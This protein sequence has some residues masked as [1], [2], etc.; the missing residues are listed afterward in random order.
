MTHS[1]LYA[2]GVVH[3]RLRPVRHRLRYAV[4]Y[5]LIDL[6]ELPDL[7]ARL[8]LFA[9]DRFGLF[10]FHQRDHGGQQTGQLRAW[11]ERHVR[12]AGLTDR[13]GDIRILCMP[14]ILGY[15]FNPISVYFCYAQGGG[16]VAMLYEVRNTFGER[17]SYLIPVRAQNETVRQACD[18]QFYVSPFMP[19]E[20]AYRFRVE[21][22]GDTIRLG[23][24]AADSEG[25]V[26]ATA[27]SGR[28]EVL[29]DSVLLRH[30]LR[31]PLLGAKIVAA[32]HWEAAKLWLRGLRLKPRP[33]PPA[34]P[35]TI[36][37]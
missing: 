8:K 2:G 20:L 31:M 5:L 15:A 24:N 10:A 33:A 37:A 35:V 26:I 1:A 11:V 9:F 29:S 3:Q 28:R 7:A 17:H 16:L 25:V 12:D 23:I 22:P 36:S 27:F 13:L 4:F 32:I 21:L 18:K 34:N 14:R 19:M 6:D 30:F